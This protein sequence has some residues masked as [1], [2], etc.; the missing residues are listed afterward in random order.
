MTEYVHTFQELHADLCL[1]FTRNTLS[2]EKTHAFID[3]W[4]IIKELNKSWD[5]QK[6]KVEPR[7]QDYQS[8]L[9]MGLGKA[10]IV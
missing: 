2:R 5:V 10:V 1:Q 4:T 6:I 3:E 7:T 9:T 8:K